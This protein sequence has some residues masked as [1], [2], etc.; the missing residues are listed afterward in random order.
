MLS[1]TDHH[2]LPPPPAS[3]NLARHVL[4]RGAEMPDRIALQ[5]LRPTGAERWSYGRLVQ[6]VRG[7]GHGL[8]QCGLR[9]GDRVVLRLGNGVAFP[10]AFLGAIAAG[11]VPV[12]TA[13]ALT[14][15][16]FQRLIDTIGPALIV[17]DKALAMP[18]S[19]PCPV[20]PSDRV[21]GYETLPPADWQMG[22]PNR[23]AYIVFTSGTSGQPQ[24]VAHAHRAVWARQTMFGGWHDIQPGDRVLHSGALNWTYTLGVGLI[25]PWTVGACAL[26]PAHGVGIETLA[27]L[28]RRFDATILA[29]VPGV[30]RR[31]LRLNPDLRLPRLRHALSAGERLSPDLRQAWRLTTGTELHEAMGLSECSTFISSSPSRPAPDGATGYAQ[32]GR[33]VAVLGEDGAPVTRGVPG[34]L[35]VHRADPG[36]FLG[37]ATTDG[38]DPVDQDWFP[39]GDTAIMA[40]DGAITVL[41]RADDMITAGGFRIAPEEIEAAFASDPEVT[42]C[43]AVE[44]SVAHDT[45]VIGLF[46]SGSASEDALK[47]HA[48]EMLAPF[49]QPRILIRRDTIPTTPNGKVSRRTL[50]E[51]WK[52]V[53]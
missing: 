34:L 48:A 35:A 18:D 3:F 9:P 50:R 39:T 2:P 11:L 32:N 29:S 53:P 24:A 40:E 33:H 37:R 5:I 8:L 43:A 26:I 49:K 12:P 17:A 47:A 36:L 27:L 22:D 45:T 1:V 21:L 52:A 25:D 31:L 10:L 38:I 30:Y 13:A 28:A 4:E 16:E 23:L 14:A 6:A 19:L 46:Y 42:A 41:G 44:L 7:V 15:A 51:E 20:L